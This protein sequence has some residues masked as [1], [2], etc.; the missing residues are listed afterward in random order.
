MV[1]FP[2]E[3]RWLPFLCCATLFVLLSCEVDALQVPSALPAHRTP[4]PT[5]RLLV[6]P[7]LFSQN[8]VTSIETNSIDEYKPEITFAPSQISLQ[9]VSLQYPVTL[10]RKLFSPVPRREF[11]VNNVSCEFGSE[12]VLLQGASSSG[13]S[14]LLKVM[15]GVDEQHKPTSGSVVITSGED[16]QVKST[17]SPIMLADKPPFDNKQ[18]VQTLLEQESR[19][20]T[21]PTISD[22]AEA[23]GFSVRAVEAICQL[24]N[25]NEAILSQTPAQLSPSENYRIRLAAACLQ[26]SI[27]G[28]IR[29]A[30]SNPIDKAKYTLPAP[31][32]FLDEWMDFETRDSSSKVEEALLKLV[33]ETGAIVVCATHK[34][35]L[36]KGLVADSKYTTQMTMCRGEILTL[37]KH[38]S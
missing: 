7:L 1:L 37:Q 11:A 8:P 26:S 3:G 27:P 20:N 6:A 14:A 29:S 13:K 12:A 28:V 16:G 23:N 21:P 30:G 17:A 32:I 35:N 33:Q 9:Q 24:T 25:L 22:V 36:W 15:A 18:T 31:I 2:R 38:S 19:Q 5:R 10:A 34:P 4:T